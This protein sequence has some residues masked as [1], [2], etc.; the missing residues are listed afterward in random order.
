MRKRKFLTF[1]KNSVIQIK[2]EFSCL[3][4]K[5]NIVQCKYNLLLNI[6]IID[7]VRNSYP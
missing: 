7:F 3:I 6:K 5:S 4:C 2:K 1:L